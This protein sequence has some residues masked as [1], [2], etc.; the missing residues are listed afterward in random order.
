MEKHYLSLEHIPAIL[1]GPKSDHL[2]IAVHGSQS[3]KSDKVIRIL[4][5]EAVLK[6]YQVLSFD[7]PKHGER[8]EEPQPY[9]IQNCVEDLSK[10][11]DYAYSCSKNISLF[12][13]S[14][15]AYFSMLAY[16][17]EEIGQT[18]F[19]TPIVDMKRIINNIMRMFD[20]SEERLQ[21]EQEISTPIETLYWDYYQYVLNHPIEWNKPTK[22]LHATN[23]NFTEFSI[24]SE[25]SKNIHARMTVLKNGE[26]YFRTEE[27]LIFFQEW[28]RNNIKSSYDLAASYQN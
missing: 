6:G 25:F 17:D 16:K 7:L 20:I 10:V 28:L 22:L 8:K 18:L 2:F 11:L 19:L 27:Q 5:E 4:A 1:W 15:G 3:N 13:C 24:I 26:H 23:D 12:G 9:K 14:I 21:K